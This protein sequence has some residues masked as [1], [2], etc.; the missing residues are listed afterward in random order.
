MRA[1]S[2]HDWLKFPLKLL[3]E[4]TPW[5]QVGYAV[6]F[7]RYKEGSIGMVPS[8]PVLFD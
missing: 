8:F 2:K 3:T 1:L 6:I 5:W 4:P 7:R